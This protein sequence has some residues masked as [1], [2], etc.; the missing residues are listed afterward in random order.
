MNIWTPLGFIIRISSK[1]MISSLMK[2][3]AKA[4]MLW[5]IWASKAWIITW[6]NKKNS[7]SLKSAEFCR[8]FS[9]LFIIC[10]KKEFAIEIWNQRTFSL[11]LI[12]VLFFFEGFYYITQK[13]LKSKLSISEFRRILSLIHSRT[14]KHPRIRQGCT[15]VQAL[16]LTARRKYLTEKAISEF[17][18]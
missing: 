12:K 6:R 14:D 7:Q 9:R 16:W 15:L 18:N 13:T 17:L 5:S 10:T 3:K 11:N 4:I 8:K 1:Y 2:S